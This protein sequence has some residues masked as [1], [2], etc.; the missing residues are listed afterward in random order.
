MAAL[1]LPD[2]YQLV[3]LAK[4]TGATMKRAA[5]APFVLL[6]P[7]VSA[8]TPPEP[9]SGAGIWDVLVAPSMDPEKS[10]V[11]ENVDIVRDRVHITLVSGTI[12]FA[13][14][15]NGVVFAAVFHGEG[16][17]R[18]DPPNATEAR[19]IYLFTRQEKLDFSFSD[20]TFSST[21]GLFE[22]VAKQVK[23][24][25]GAASDDLFA[26]RQQERE[27][28]GAEQLPRLFKSAMSPDRK[29]TGYFLADLKSKDKSWIEICDDAMQPEEM[30]VGRWVD[31]GPFKIF[32]NWTIFPAGGRDPRHVYDDPAAK[33]DFLIPDYR[34][35]STVTEGAELSAA[36]HVTTQPRYSGENV[37]LF[38]L[39]SN[40]RL[41]S[42][43]DEKG[44]SLAFHQAVERK[45]HSQSS[46]DYVAVTLAEPTQQG[47]GQAFDFQY[48]GK[49]VIH[50]HGG[51]NYF[52]Q[53]FGW[54][55]T[56]FLAGPGVSDAAFR[57][58][59]DITFHS[60]KK[61]KLVATGHKTSETTD[62]KEL[63]TT[64]KSDIPLAFAGFAFGDYKVF[65]DRLGDIEVRCMRII[66]RMN[67]CKAFSNTL[68]IRSTILPWG[69]EGGRILVRPCLRSAT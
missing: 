41:D 55:A 1:A 50:K 9:Q 23:W 46:G 53:S 33:M 57:A 20:A 47:Q 54:Y 39:D 32:D 66:S 37:P 44:R 31:V 43:K 49:H 6:V 15:V 67:S 60:P 10:A 5:L 28:L 36:A 29:R 61:Y 3:S 2:E 25:P 65:T 24:K 21:D 22:E 62:G 64:W 48:A 38:E 42:V 26:K 16:K 40:L 51:G 56:L 27:S 58:N 34:L 68:R 7:F 18:L 12:Q 35:T 17:V 69:L 63:V 19:Q 30:R 13:K 14:P 11:A 59:F 4:G 52:C 8:Q 45:K